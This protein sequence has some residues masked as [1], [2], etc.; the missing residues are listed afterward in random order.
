MNI[1]YHKTLLTL[2]AVSLLASG[3]ALAQK[4]PGRGDD[5]GWHRPSPPTAED[6]L[7]R[8]S[9]ALGL[10]PEQSLQMLQIMQE[11]E[12]ERAALREETMAL[13]GDRICT[14]RAE[15]EQ[16][17]L[18]ILTDEQAELFLQFKSERE[19]RALQRGGHHFGPECSE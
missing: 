2:V 9:N 4:G 18:D 1:R 10:T 6:R 17:V 8:M 15:H 13:M 14:Q 16:A 7:A 19:A 12:Q 11:Q 3:T 5:D